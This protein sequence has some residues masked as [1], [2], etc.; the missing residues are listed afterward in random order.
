MAI[1]FLFV[2]ALDLVAW[3]VDASGSSQGEQLIDI[4]LS[5]TLLFKLLYFIDILVVPQHA[6]SQFYCQT[7]DNTYSYAWR[8]N[9][10]WDDNINNS[11]FPDVIWISSQTLSNGSTRGSLT[12]RAHDQANNTVIEC[13]ITNG[14]HILLQLNYK[15]TVQG[16]YYNTLFIKDLY[17]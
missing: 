3:Q 7:P 11:T 8:V 16:S 14:F 5:T 15:M 13:F 10:T 17:W 12:F 6:K 1:F 2:I 4:L 9:G